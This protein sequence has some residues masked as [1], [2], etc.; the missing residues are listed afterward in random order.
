LSLSVPPPVMED[1]TVGSFPTVFPPQFSCVGA[2]PTECSCLPLH[3][4]VSFFLSPVAKT[5]YEVARWGLS[6][7]F[8]L[9]PSYDD[10][11][12]HSW[13]FIYVL[14]LPAQCPSRRENTKLPSP[15]TIHS[16]IGQDGTHVLYV[17]LEGV[18]PSPGTSPVL[19]SFKF[20]ARVTTS[21]PF[22]PGIIH[23][24]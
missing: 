7:P 21:H 5:V 23:L 16:F 4:P 22:F 8:F 11:F 13:G 17:W 12:S 24:T 9:S 1:I 14:F 19:D 18:T 10:H 20:S 2:L 6:S 3:V 15:S